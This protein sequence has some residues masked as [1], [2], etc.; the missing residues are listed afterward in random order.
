MIS[1]FFMGFINDF[2]MGS[3]VTI[4]HSPSRFGVRQGQD[5]IAVLTVIAIGPVG[6]IL[7]PSH[8]L[9]GTIGLADLED[10]PVNRKWLEN[11]CSCYYI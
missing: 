2:P 4:H 7:R 10:H 8:A 1:P 5:V 6:I 11:M 9:R 3:V